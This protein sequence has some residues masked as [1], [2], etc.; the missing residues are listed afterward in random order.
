MKEKDKARE[1]K[2]KDKAWGTKGQR[3][4]I[5]FVFALLLEFFEKVKEGV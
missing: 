3:R 2:G 1:Q 5:A 4:E